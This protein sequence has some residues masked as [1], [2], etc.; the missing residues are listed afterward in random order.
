MEAAWR[1]VDGI[2]GDRTPL[3]DYDQG[4][5]GPEEAGGILARG[6]HWHGPAV[7]APS[8]AATAVQRMPAAAS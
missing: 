8:V 6:D 3:H 1:V 4:T 7:T 2:L 5:W